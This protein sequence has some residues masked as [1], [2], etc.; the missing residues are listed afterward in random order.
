MSDFVTTYPV[1][2]LLSEHDVPD[3]VEIDGSVCASSFTLAGGCVSEWTVR[4]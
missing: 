2:F 4:L 1:F 3:L